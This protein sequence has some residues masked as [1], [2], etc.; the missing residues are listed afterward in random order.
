MKG[1]CPECD[2]DIEIPDDA[3]DNEV[4][5][6]NECGIDIAI[7]PAKEGRPVELTKVDLKGKDWGE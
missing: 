6:C 5:T 4:I 3:V 2:A 7:T 1:K